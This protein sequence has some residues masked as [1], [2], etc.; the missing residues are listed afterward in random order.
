MLPSDSAMSCVNV[1]GRLGRRRR[2]A[3]RHW[4]QM[5]DVD[6]ADVEDVED[7]STDFDRVV[8]GPV[9]DVTRRKEV[10]SD[11]VLSIDIF[12]CISAQLRTFHR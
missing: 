2:V 6:G 3:C 9:L 8:D 1:Y 4:L 11:M 12:S 7:F 5:Y 10:L